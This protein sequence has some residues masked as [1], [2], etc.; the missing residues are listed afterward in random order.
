MDKTK[1]GAIAALLFLG[2]FLALSKSRD[3][4]APAAD[5]D[6]E[7]AAPAPTAEPKLVGGITR[8][9]I[10]DERAGK[11]VAAKTGD[12]LTLNYKGS[13]LDGSVFDQSYGRSPFSF[14]L[15]Q[16]QVIRG[17]D[18]GLLGMKAGGKRRLLIPASLGYGA[19]GAGEKIPGGATLKF[20]VELLKISHSGG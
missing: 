19:Q 11:G 10:S 1:L 16:G 7:S 2:G 6:H 12:S 3:V 17:W 15:G 13:L 4:P 20:E 18:Q 5:P 8:L 14:V 9:Q